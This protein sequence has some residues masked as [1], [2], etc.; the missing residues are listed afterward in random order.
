MNQRITYSLI[1]VL[2]TV[3]AGL[4]FIVGHD[5]YEP[6]WQLVWTE[7][8]NGS[9]LDT[10]VW[11]YMERRADESR[12][13]HSSN[14]DCYEF[15]KGKLILKG[16]ENKKFDYDTAKYL[17]GG[18]TTKGKKA[19]APGKIEIRAK[20]GSAAG[21]WPAFWMLPFNNYK[22]W[23][24]DGEIDIME[25]LNHDNFI[26]QSVHSAYT[27]SNCTPTVKRSVK[28]NINKNDFNIYGVA[29]TKKYI[30]F[31]V[32]RKETLTYPRVDSLAQ[33]EQYPFNHDWYIMLDMQLG[34]NWSGPVKPSELPVEIII[35]WVKYYQ[36]IEP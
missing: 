22:G 5:D 30:K 32:N 14:S 12:K 10:T 13:Y 8:F 4:K 24:N 18:I 9:S 35:D 31:Y 26:Y 17:T 29:F 6:K 3:I 23:P 27:K 11:G 21:A 7:N 16:I 34:G 36:I 25:H 33:K 1:L 28:A 15:K 19:F 2:I 20:I